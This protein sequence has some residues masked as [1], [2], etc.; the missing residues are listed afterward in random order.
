MGLIKNYPQFNPDIINNSTAVPE[1]MDTAD[2]LAMEMHE[3]Y[4]LTKHKVKKL[5]AE[6]LDAV[7]EW[8]VLPGK[9]ELNEYI[10]FNSKP[11][12][13]GT[14]RKIQEHFGNIGMQAFKYLN[15]E[16][17]PDHDITYQAELTIKGQDSYTTTNLGSVLYG[18][19]YDLP[20]ADSFSITSYYKGPSVVACP[21]SDQENFTYK[22][23]E[24]L[25]NHGS[26]WCRKYE[27]GHW[28][29]YYHN[30]WVDLFEKD[31]IIT[32]MISYNTDILDKNY[33]MKWWCWN[34]D[35]YVDFDFNKHPHIL[36]A[37]QDA[38]RRHIPKDQLEYCEGT[39][40]DGEYQIL[41]HSIGWEPLKL[42]VVQDFLDEINAIIEP[43]KNE[44]SCDCEGDW[45][46][47]RLPFAVATWVWT[48]DGFKVIGVEY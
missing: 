39:W 6:F 45:Y 2:E 41:V 10:E 26:G 13:D 34:L 4:V 16:I 37:L 33:G 14:V 31:S 12:E 30:D 27:N 48:D 22:A 19:F 23:F 20:D 47:T 18:I 36:S 35:L 8:H 24:F 43:I 40:E 28:L 7:S 1:S 25:F 46:I 11:L 44:C 38:V 42:R 17:E 32:E 21:L 9:V 5:K 15:G 29:G 3:D